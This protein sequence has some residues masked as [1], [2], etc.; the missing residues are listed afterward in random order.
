[1]HLRHIRNG[2]AAHCGAPLQPA[3]TTF[4]SIEEAEGYL[5]N[6]AARVAPCPAC[7]NDAHVRVLSHPMAGSN[8]ASDT[9]VIARHRAGLL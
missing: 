7:W 1:M 9:D 3:D 2:A 5:T 4:N 6:P 8:V